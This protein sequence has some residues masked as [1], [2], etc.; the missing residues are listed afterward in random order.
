MVSIRSTVV[1]SKLFYTFIAN[2]QNLC[3][4]FTDENFLIAINEPREL[5]GIFDT[6]KAV[7]SIRKFFIT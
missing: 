1:L 3:Y 6:K 4:G 5:I 7:V 2:L